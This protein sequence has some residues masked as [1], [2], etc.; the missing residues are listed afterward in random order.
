MRRKILNTFK[1]LVICT[2]LSVAVITVAALF[3]DQKYYKQWVEDYVTEVTGRK[4]QIDGSLR[5]SLEDGVGF[6]AE[7]IRFAN[8]DWADEP[9]AV[10]AEKVLV[11][12]SLMGLFKGEAAIRE[13]ELVG[14]NANVRFNESGQS[15]WQFSSDDKQNA[16][17][18]VALP[19]WLILDKLV[20]QDSSLDIVSQSGASWP[21]KLDE[22]NLVTR[23]TTSDQSN[24]TFD[25]L[26][27]G[28]IKQVPI[29]ATLN[30]GARSAIWARQPV[31]VS[32]DA[33][34]GESKSVV[35]AQGQ[36]GDL[37][38]WSGLDLQVDAGV[39]D[40]ADFSAWTAG[41]LPATGTIELSGRVLQPGS[42]NTLGLQELDIK[43]NVGG[44]NTQLEGN[45]ENLADMQGID[46]EILASGPVNIDELK[47]EN[48]SIGEGNIDFDMS[49]QGD[50]DDLTA[51]VK[52]ANLIF[53]GFELSANGESVLQE[54]A[55]RSPI[56][57][58]FN[59]DSLATIGEMTG[60]DLVESGAVSGQFDWLLESGTHKLSAVDIK[61]Q[62]GPH[63]GSVTGD[64]SMSGDGA[65]GELIFDLSSESLDWINRFAGQHTA[66][67]QWMSPQSVKTQG[68]ASLNGDNY[69]LS[70]DNA[71]YESEKLVLQIEGDIGFSP[72]QNEPLTSVSLDVSGTGRGL[73][74][75]PYLKDVQ[76]PLFPDITLDGKV[77]LNQERN[78]SLQDVRL[79]AQDEM[80]KM[81]LSG[82]VRDVLEDLIIEAETN[83]EIYDAEL[84]KPYLKNEEILSFL[85]DA[86]P[87]NA[88]AELVWSESGT[89]KLS[90]VEI[91]S[92]AK[93]IN[94]R[95]EGEVSD[96]KQG[97]GALTFDYSGVGAE[98]YSLS[99][100]VIRS[101]SLVKASSN[102]ELD[103]WS[104]KF[105]TFSLDILD[106]ELNLSLGGQLESVSP[107]SIQNASVSMKLAS[108]E[109]LGLIKESQ[110]RMDIPLRADIDLSVEQKEI[111]AEGEIIFG[112]S[113][114]SGKVKYSLSEEQKPS[115][116]VAQLV[117]RNL[118][119]TEIIKKSPPRKELFS[120]DPIS[121]AWTQKFSGNVE[122]KAERFKNNMVEVS[123]L[124]ANARATSSEV[125]MLFKGNMGDG[126][127]D[128]SM[129]LDLGLR[130]PQL[131]LEILGA[132]LDSDGFVPLASNDFLNKGKMGMDIVFSGTGESPKSIASTAAGSA[133]IWI[134]DAQ[135]K[136]EGIDLFG[137]DLLLTVMST[138]NP[139]TRRG[140][141]LNVECGVLNFDINE[142]VARNK[143]GIA[144]K[145]SKV[146]V[147][148]GG[149]LSLKDE[150]L[151]I[152]LRPKARKGFGIN[153]N[154]VA[155]MVR[156]G[157]NLTS[158]EVQTDAT[159][160]LQSGV[161][162][163]AAIASGGLSLIAQGLF[164]RSQANADV[165][166]LART[167]QEF[168]E[169]SGVEVQTID[170]G[171]KEK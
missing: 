146:T 110:F 104:A 113:D 19:N 75:L 24:G 85:D 23:N 44:A 153:A 61:I 76:L 28:L 83:V 164:D 70:L 123:N 3:I 115:H 133:E 140:D 17:G 73:E 109:R 63:T 45:I 10:T 95:I 158:P 118:D 71:Q 160:L 149:S 114:I 2:I 30:L 169:D 138:I 127:L 119:L 152:V 132:N 12:Q 47:L 27:S 59:V 150:N 43:A 8:P 99:M 40:L 79:Y 122:L 121:L 125:S 167:D 9:W 18:K 107:L 89:Q 94:T 29:Q 145:T 98:L 165:C 129:D 103:N 136:N 130:T 49:L 137:G 7:Q 55:G 64:V 156:L 96:L 41:E 35:R 101:D 42:A 13:I 11:D 166:V 116:V 93:D 69:R 105:K 163:G 15:N 80:V 162:I 33:L 82:E 135:M 120:A 37:L 56:A 148:G 171:K 126:E 97:K 141:Y 38:S 62:E 32:L 78:L 117:S 159:G 144:V 88:R 139:F 74:S 6:I 157:G 46:L 86:L 72:Q 102:I 68:M 65:V 25:G 134:T 26:V 147:L 154:S 36:I 91:S 106:K 170:P 100:P 131:N 5:F 4:L 51:N 108:L 60:I 155:K 67:I 1:W 142:G 66:L 58:K 57:F 54:A 31:S 52:K 161:A 39:E 124:N 50:Q 53:P 77:D 20:I 81:E 16:K 84:L 90:N 87:I 143:N 34:L 21:V 48:L 14:V 128:V 111:N 168:S 151:K 22:V 92:D 112:Y